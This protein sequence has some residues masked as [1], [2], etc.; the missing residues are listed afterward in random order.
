MSDPPAPVQSPFTVG[1]TASFSK[2]A[3]DADVLFFLATSGD[4]NPVH[5]DEEAARQSQFGRRI[6]P[7]MWSAGLISAVLGTRMPG[8]GTIYLS[9]TLNFRRPVYINDTITATVEVIAIRHDKN[10]ITLKT[11]VTNQASE[12]ILEGEALVKAP[13]A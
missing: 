2:T 8:P 4:T 9:Q 12:L 11:T 5:I 3:T 7:G 13:R 6:L 10:I 1:Q